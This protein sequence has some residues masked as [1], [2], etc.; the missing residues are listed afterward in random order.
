MALCANY[1]TGCKGCVPT[2]CEK[3]SPCVERHKDMMCGNYRKGCGNFVENKLCNTC[4]DNN[5]IRSERVAI[6]PKSELKEVVKEVV[7]EVEVIK[8]VIKEVVDDKKLLE[9]QSDLDDYINYVKELQGE[10]EEAH[11]ENESLVKQLN[12]F[13][14]KFSENR[15]LFL[16]LQFEK[17]ALLVENSRLKSGIESSP[18]PEYFI[19]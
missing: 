15:E 19:C 14:C 18:I 11:T 9:I 8:E 6:A 12:E 13:N 16:K 5:I 3:C 17:D 4:L 7:K 2:L 1:K 10:L